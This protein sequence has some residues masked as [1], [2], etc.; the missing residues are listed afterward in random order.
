MIINLSKKRAEFLSNLCSTVKNA[1]EM[2]INL[3][4]F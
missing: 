4:T 2:T 3:S 1:Y